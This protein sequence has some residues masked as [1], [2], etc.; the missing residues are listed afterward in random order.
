MQQNETLPI[1]SITSDDDFDITL[2]RRSP[3]YDGHSLRTFTYWPQKLTDIPQVDEDEDIECYLI[4]GI[5]LKGD[6]EV[7]HKGNVMTAKELFLK[8]QGDI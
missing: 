7:S 4:N 8:Y 3:S 2:L 6:T 5:L 1:M